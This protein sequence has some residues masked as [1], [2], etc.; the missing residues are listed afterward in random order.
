MLHGLPPPTGKGE[1]VKV[2]E[3]VFVKKEKMIEVKYLNFLKKIVKMWR[4]YEHMILNEVTGKEIDQLWK[5]Y[6]EYAK[7]IE[8][9]KG[10]IEKKSSERTIEQ[11]YKDIM[12]LLEGAYGKKSEN[13]MVKTFENEMIKKKKLP[14]FYLRIL[15]DVIEARKKFKKGKMARHEVEEARKNG[16]LLINHLIDYNQRC[17]LLHLDENKFKLK[18]KEGV[19]ELVLTEKEAFVVGED[20]IVKINVEDGK[21]RESS[22][23]EMGKAL[24]KEI[25]KELKVSGKMFEILK[26][27]FGEF[28]LVI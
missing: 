13:E 18:T 3:D 19:Y 20:S 1:I 4:D 24:G 8:E 26:K 22:N 23:E 28:E 17:E 5:E 14:D 16:S 7:R 2:M 10:Q 9:L 25:K 11:L 21:M 15:E 27:H 6:Q 12:N